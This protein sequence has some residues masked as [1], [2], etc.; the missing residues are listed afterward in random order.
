MNQIFS[1]RHRSFKLR[2]PSIRR[3]IRCKSKAVDTVSDPENPP[4]PEIPEEAV[5]LNQL[6]GTDSLPRL[7][8]SPCKS[9][10]K[11]NRSENSHSEVLNE[12]ENSLQ[13]PTVTFI[14]RASSLEGLDLKTQDKYDK[15]GQGDSGDFIIHFS[16]CTKVEVIEGFKVNGYTSRDVTLPFS[17]LPPFPIWVNS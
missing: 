15:L 10:E 6:L 11:L 13:L 12:T 14:R 7:N 9:P 17:F 4:I 5:P 2:L 16:T 8:S 3:D 1:D